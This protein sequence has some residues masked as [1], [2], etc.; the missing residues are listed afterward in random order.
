MTYTYWMGADKM[1][2]WDGKYL[3]LMFPAL[4][5]NNYRSLKTNIEIFSTIQGTPSVIALRPNAAP[6]VMSLRWVYVFTLFFFH[7]CKPN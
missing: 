7:C 4:Q 6:F 1:I 5:E 2:N 3:M